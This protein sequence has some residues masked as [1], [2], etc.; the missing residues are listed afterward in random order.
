MS[1][2][3]I[4]P[5]TFD[6]ITHGHLDLITRAAQLFDEVIVAVATSSSKQPMFNLDEREALIKQTTCNLAN[7][8]VMGFSGLLVDFAKQQQA[9]VLIRGLRTVSDFEYEFQL[10]NMNRHLMPDLET[11]FL[12]PSPAYSFVSSSLIKDVVRHGGDISQFVPE[13]VASAITLKLVKD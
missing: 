9:N 4:Y 13:A 11:V 10:S 6:P 2:R 5:G 3:V 8:H 7:V 1:T 12:T